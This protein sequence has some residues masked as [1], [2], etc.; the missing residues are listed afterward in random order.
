MKH[1]K[2]KYKEIIQISLVII[3]FIGVFTMTTIL[4]MKQDECKYEFATILM[5]TNKGN[6]TIELNLK[7]APMTS[8]NFIKLTENK[9]YDNLKFHRYVPN[10][11]IQGGDPKGDGTGG[12]GENLDLEISNLSHEKGVIAMAR[13]SEPNSASSQFYFTLEKTPHL[14]GDYA[15]FGKVNEGMDVVMKLRE[16]DIMK[17]V[18]LINY[19]CEEK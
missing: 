10:F 6:I 18:T 13:T 14:D 4:K 11:V 9:F 7:E 3:L 19:I 1:N 12:S 8:K 16:G 5:E 17:K 15:V 2:K